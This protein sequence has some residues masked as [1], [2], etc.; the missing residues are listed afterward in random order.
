MR[1]DWGGERKKLPPS[2]LAPLPL[3]PQAFSRSSVTQR[4]TKEPESKLFT[5]SRMCSEPPENLQKPPN[6]E[7]TRGL[8]SQFLLARLPGQL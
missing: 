3:V 1:R 4:P 6:E 5:T 8:T 2:F 7:P